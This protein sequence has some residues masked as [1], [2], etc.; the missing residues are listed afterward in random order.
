MSDTRR[1]FRR[2]L[3]R[4][5]L[6]QR[7]RILAEADACTER[8][9]LAALLRKEDINRSL[10]CY[11][12]RRRDA[13]AAKALA[14]AV[15]APSSNGSTHGASAASTEPSPA[16]VATLE[17]K[18]QALSQELQRVQSRLARQERVIH[19]QHELYAMQA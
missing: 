8:G 19:L 13:E 15:C 16:Y 14:Q 2:G 3:R 5:T 1:S 7:A 17:Q 18:L 11:W 12:R 6:E 10:L 9:Q 4:F